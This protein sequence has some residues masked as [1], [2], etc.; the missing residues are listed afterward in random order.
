[1]VKTKRDKNKFQVITFSCGFSRVFG[2]TADK[3]TFLKVAKK[4]KKIFKNLLDN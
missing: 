3:N 1:M 4:N 2:K